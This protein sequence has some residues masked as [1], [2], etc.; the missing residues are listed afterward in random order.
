[1]PDR[2]R[3]NDELLNR[4]MQAFVRSP[5]GRSFLEPFDM[6]FGECLAITCLFGC[7]AM[8]MVPT[9]VWTLAGLQTLWGI[10]RLKTFEPMYDNAAK[11]PEKLRPLIGHGIIIGPDQVHSL[12]L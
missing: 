9:I 1:M 7:L 4:N 10:I 6:S 12:V 11:Q 3:I 5:Q 8:C 2:I